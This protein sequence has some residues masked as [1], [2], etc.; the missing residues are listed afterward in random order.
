MSNPNP[1]DHHYDALPLT[2]D[3]HNSNS[4][5]NAPPSPGP[6]SR[7]DT[8]LLDSDHPL[9]AN[10][11]DIPLGAAQP[12]FMGP[13]L[14]GEPAGFSRDSYAS[15]HNTYPSQPSEFNDSVY[16]LNPINGNNRSSTYRDDPNAPGDVPMSPMGS[17]S[18]LE[19]KRAA[20]VAPR[21]RSKRRMVVII[22][23]VVGLIIAIAVIV[24]I[25]FAVI[26]PKSK[27]DDNGSSDSNSGDSHSGGHGDTAALY[28]K[29][30]GDGSEI[31]MEDGTKF[32]Y[33]NA[34][35]GTWYWDPNDPLNNNAQAQSYT[36]PLNTSFK[37]GVDRIRG[38]NLGG[39]LNT[40]PFIVPAIYEQY[41]NLPTP[42][43][44][45]WTLSE[46]MAADTA[47]GGLKQLED[48]YKTFITEQDFA[49][50]A[51]AGLNW[52]RIP[53]AWWAIEV[54]DNEPFLPKT[55]WTYFLK[56]IQWARKYGLR[57]NLD[58]HAV[59]GSQNGWNHSGRL[60]K[61]SFL[62]GPMGYANAQRALDYIRIIAEFISQPQYKDVVA[63]FGI[64]NEPQVIQESSRIQIGS[65]QL[66][67]FYVEAYRI[68][69][70]ITGTGEGKGPMISY[71]DGFISRSNWAGFMTN[72][73]R[74]ALD[75]HPYLC[76]NNDQS[77]APYSTYADTPCSAWGKSFNDSMN[78]FGLSGAGEWSNAVT[79]CGLYVNGV[80]LGTR[81]EGTYPPVSKVTGDCTEWTDYQKWSTSKKADVKR[82]AMA[83]MDALGNYF[84]WTWR[85]GE[86]KASGK[87][88]APQWSYKLGLEEGWMP[89]DPRD[90]DGICENI[91]PHAPLEPWQTGGSGAGDIPAASLDAYPWPP[92]SI[93]NAGAPSNLPQYTPT[94]TIITLP[95]P[96]F[97]TTSDGTVKVTTTPDLG[98]GWYHSADTTSLAVNPSGCPYLDPWMGEADIPAPCGGAAGA[99]RREPSPAM[100]TAAP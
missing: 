96:T 73:D 71:H 32:T 42:P 18:R 44:D 41:G 14:Y 76:F 21:A 28:T 85:I 11:S 5:Y 13:A 72:A 99:A 88:E 7:Y 49:E 52:I 67:G 81:Y 56:A 23:S 100:V 53:I 80:G 86:S 97:S 20:Y 89:K 74:I 93:A 51:G 47:N 59:P 39:W 45:E 46:A 90:A 66:R 25:Y 8:P 50:I 12:R 30:G 35:G 78:Q 95:N 26:K 69:R 3:E 57:I 70:E 98:N 55:S 34:L 75:S 38:V 64:L 33:K 37:Y 62:N 58:L 92:V 17:S 65:D 31:V 36:P 40:E 60:G 16:A 54:R 15:S 87:V 83:S 82:F 22:G 9:P 94:G 68:I 79:D 43:I 91:N 61:I 1:P 27:D 84:F 4:L 48:H 19:E 77:S 10:G 2:S 63:M 24:A 6:T 29:S